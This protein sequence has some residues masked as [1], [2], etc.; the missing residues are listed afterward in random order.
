MLAGAEGRVI[1]WVGV[2]RGESCFWIWLEAGTLAELETEGW[3]QVTGIGEE[4]GIGV[5][6][7]KVCVGV[8]EGVEGRVR[9]VWE[10]AGTGEEIRVGGG[11]APHSREED[12]GV[13]DTLALGLWGGGIE[14]ETKEEGGEEEV[15]DDLGPYV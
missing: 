8:W 1:V 5:T 11:L 6:G 14:D 4:E 15:R 7:V 9:V 2:V 12:A 13:L 10:G 3:R